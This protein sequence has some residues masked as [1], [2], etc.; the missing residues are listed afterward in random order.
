MEHLPDADDAT[1]VKLLRDGDAEAWDVLTHRYSGRLWAIAR[2]LRLNEPD[3]ADVVQTAWLR[4]LEH[5]QRL[6]EPEHVGSWLAT[7]VR[8]ECLRTLRRRDRAAPA[9]LL[10]GLPDDGDEPDG[11]LLRDERST[12]LWRALRALDVRCQTLLRVL[13]AEPAPAYQDVAAALDM[14]I[15]SIGPTRKRCLA[16]LRGLLTTAPGPV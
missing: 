16:K 6:R 12:A 7:T 14:Q 11:R 4:L 2:A 13:M 1:L 15:G 10:D 3:A 5:V 9:E 8:H